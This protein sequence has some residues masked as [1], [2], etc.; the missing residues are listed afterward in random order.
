MRAGAMR[1]VLEIHN[2]ITSTDSTGQE[3]YSYVLYKKVY[4][5]LKRN[6]MSKTEDGFIQ[7]SGTDNVDMTLRYD[8]NIGFNSRVYWSG[9]WYR[10]TK[11]DN[12]MNLNHQLDLTLT[13]VEL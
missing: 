4:G 9:T 10:I 5:A 2:P 1:Q 11:A 3:T 12:V 8:P 6:S 13:A 7:A